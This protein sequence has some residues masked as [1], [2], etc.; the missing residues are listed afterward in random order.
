MSEDYVEDT[1]GEINS[2]L[3]S[4][5]DHSAIVE[6]D[7][8][9]WGDVSEEIGRFEN[10]NVDTPFTTEQWR[11][12]SKSLRNYIMAKRLLSKVSNNIDPMS[13]PPNV[14]LEAKSIDDGNV[15]VRPYSL[16]KAVQQSVESGN[17]G[18]GSSMQR[19]AS[20]LMQQDIGQHSIKKEASENRSAGA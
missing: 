19:I 12:F 10:F 3:G 1:Q 7:D 4:T 5:S 8:F 13:Y 11:T 9:I 6:M 20:N 18:I 2:E 16:S 17:E 14:D 15:T